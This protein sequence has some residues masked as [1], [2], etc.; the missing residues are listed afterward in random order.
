MR[1]G[2]RHAGGRR[3]TGRSSME[4][5]GGASSVELDELRQELEDEKEKGVS[6]VLTP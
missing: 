6:R 4:A 1:Y 2:R 3:T 5:G